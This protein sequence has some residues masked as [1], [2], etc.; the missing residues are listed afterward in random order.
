MRPPFIRLLLWRSHCL[1]SLYIRKQQNIADVCTCV[2]LPYT[3][4]Y[5]GR[6]LDF[7]VK[8]VFNVTNTILRSSRFSFFPPVVRTAVS[9]RLIG[10]YHMRSMC[11][12]ALLG[13]RR[14]MAVR[15]SSFSQLREL[16]LR[17]QVSCHAPSWNCSLKLRR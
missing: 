15:A 11:V 6:S 3:P 7:F 4:K 10:R 17:C 16:F 9:L 1:D 8:T 12:P 14:G 13:S 2:S 5:E